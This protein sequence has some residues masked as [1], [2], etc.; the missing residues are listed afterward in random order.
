MNI[1]HILLSTMLKPTEKAYMHPFNTAFFFRLFAVK[2]FK[3]FPKHNEHG[4]IS[5]V[6]ALI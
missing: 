5:E 3:I 2:S 6:F 4:F 1:N